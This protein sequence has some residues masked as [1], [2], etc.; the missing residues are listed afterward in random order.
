MDTMYTLGE[1]TVREGHED[2]FVDAWLAF[3]AWTETVV[4]SPGWAKLL[5]DRDDSSRFIS[6]GPWPDEAAVAAW[7]DHPGFQS[8]VA[9]IQG[10]LEDFTPHTMEVAAEAGPPTP[11]P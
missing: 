10:L 9:E 11:D 7:R 1:W 6:F 5:R 8:R 2:D 3:G 4:D